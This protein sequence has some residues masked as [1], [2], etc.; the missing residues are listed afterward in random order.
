[1]FNLKN[2]WFPQSH[3]QKAKINPTSRH[4]HNA[5]CS[6]LIFSRG[7]HQAHVSRKSRLLIYESHPQGNEKFMSTM[8][9]FS[10]TDSL[11]FK[12]RSFSC[13]LDLI[14]LFK[15]IQPFQKGWTL[16]PDVLVKQSK[17]FHFWTL[18]SIIS[19]KSVTC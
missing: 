19:Q 17:M 4:I 5:E 7:W 15:Q 16:K 8:S 2:W 14:D 12:D 9:P 6:L 11:L 1:M 18:K 13:T 3:D 10:R